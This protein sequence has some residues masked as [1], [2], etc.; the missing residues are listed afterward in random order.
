MSKANAVLRQ[1]GKA[2][3]DLNLLKVLQ[4]EIQHELSC[5]PPEVSRS[6]S[7]GEFVVDCE[8]PVSQDLVLRRKYDSG[9]EV[10]VSAL[11]G[12]FSPDGLE[13]VEC[14]YPRDVLMKMCLKKPGLSSMLHKLDNELQVELKKYL[15][16]KGIGES[17]TNI[18][19]HHLHKKEQAQYV[20]W[21][22]KLESYVAKSE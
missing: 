2:L 18:L 22:H 16:S 19:L 3:K 12:P 7:M 13:G 15:V 14:L 17:L 8:L 10:A 11:L 9:E 4:S 6:S 21:L 5:N 20:D 1:G